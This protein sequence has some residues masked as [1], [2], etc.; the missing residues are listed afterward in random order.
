MTRMQWAGLAAVVAVAALAAAGAWAASRF[1]MAAK[2][3][4]AYTNTRDLPSPLVGRPAP[5]LSLPLAGGG[6]ANL[7]DYQGRTVLVSFWSSF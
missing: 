3:K 7:A 4:N 6:S 5:P 2:T 1:Q